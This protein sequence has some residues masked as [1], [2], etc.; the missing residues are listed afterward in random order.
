MKRGWEVPA[1]QHMRQHKKFH[2]LI[3]QIGS[4]S[5]IPIVL[6]TSFNLKDQT[7]TINPDQA[8][9]RFLNSGI[10]FLVINNFLIQKKK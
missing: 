9:K 1:T 6:N 4:Q 8:I 10:D 7:I 2:K 3:T 5:G